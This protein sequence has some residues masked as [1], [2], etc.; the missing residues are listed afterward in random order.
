L[1]EVGDVLGIG[2]FHVVQHI[3]PRIPERIREILDIPSIV[4]I[5][6]LLLFRRFFELLLLHKLRK[7]KIEISEKRFL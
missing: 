5:L 3:F 1:G 7:N 2:R 4:I 6:F